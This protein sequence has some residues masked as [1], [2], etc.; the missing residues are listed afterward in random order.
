MRNQLSSSIFIL[1]ILCLAYNHETHR[2]MTNSPFFNL[3]KGQMSIMHKINCNLMEI[4][5][6]NDMI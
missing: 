4:Q 3:E 5:L 2:D 6:M 1:V